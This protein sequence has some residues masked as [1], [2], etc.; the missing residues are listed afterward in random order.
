[1]VEIWP[2]GGGKST[3]AELTIVALAARRRRKYCLYV[4]GTQEQADDHV[5]NTGNLFETPTFA[6][7]YPSVAQ[8]AINK[9]GSSKGWRRNRLRTASGFTVD[10]IGLDTAARGVKLE[11]ARP[12][13]IV[14]DDI[15]EETDN[16]ASTDKK[17]LEL[18]RK[19]LPS[20]AS[21]SAVLC[22][23]NLVIADGV[24]SRLAGIDGSTE[25]DIL[26]NRIV[27]GPYP[28]VYE[29]EVVKKSNKY[30][31]INGRPLW[32][33][34][35]LAKCQEQIE[36]WGYTSWKVEAQQEVMLPPGGLFSQIDFEAIHVLPEDVPDLV[37]TVVWVDPAVTSSDRSDSHGIHADGLW[38]DPN[39]DEYTIY[40]LRS[41]EGRATPATSLEKAIIW[42]LELKSDHVGVETDQGGDVWEV[43]YNAVW[44]RLL[45]MPHLL[46]RGT[47][48]DSK[49]N[50]VFDKAGAGYGPKTHRASRMLVDYEQDRFRHVLGTHGALERALGRFPL[51]KPFDLTD[52][53]FWSWND[54]KTGTLL[55]AGS[56]FDPPTPAPVLEGPPVRRVWPS[57]RPHTTFARPHA[58][59]TLWRPNMPAREE[60]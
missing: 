38:Q 10:A 35:D 4:S 19:L 17:I 45:T 43:A 13:L 54:L 31:L 26:Q 39:S 44:D 5:Q 37:R 30:Y 25:I 56:S 11:E 41:W 15:D 33:G 22:I 20:G 8:R 57:S 21:D 14:L 60:S 46:P 27:L 42:A 59:R 58:A 29:P 49:P 51:R 18:S 3:T 47:T 1:M 36:E 9:Y 50:F 34:Q 28:A 16:P 24:F 48:P 23:Q 6:E 7:Y 40:R 2:R 52:A 12:D 53:A 32:E 55:G